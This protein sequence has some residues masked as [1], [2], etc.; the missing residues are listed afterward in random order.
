MATMITALENESVHIIDHDLPPHTP[1]KKQ[2]AAGGGGVPVHSTSL[3]RALFD[4]ALHLRTRGVPAVALP[5]GSGKGLTGL[6]VHYHYHYH[7]HR[8][9][10]VLCFR[11]FA[12]KPSL[13]D[14]GFSFLT[15][16]SSSL[17]LYL[18]V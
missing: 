1:H 12:A 7:Y 2:A 10:G 18:A 8:V 14:Y 6:Q 15:P 5:P 16:P 4:F 13:T 9:F 11:I 17:L 3:L